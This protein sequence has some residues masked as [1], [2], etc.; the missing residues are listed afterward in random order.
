MK[1]GIAYADVGGQ[2]WLRLDVPDDAT[3]GRAIEQSGLLASHPQIDLENQKV[4]V[5]GK[6]VALDAP[7]Q[8]GDRI[9]IYRAIVCDPTQVPR[10]GG[11]DDDD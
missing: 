5:F 3:V 6:V 1:V 9:E 7:L 4:G 10:R 11:C 2:V 8:P